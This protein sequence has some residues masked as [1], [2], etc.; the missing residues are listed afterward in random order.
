MAVDQ[1]VAVCLAIVRECLW[2]SK[3]FRSIVTDLSLPPVLQNL[4]NLEASMTERTELAHGDGWYWKP[5]AQ[6]HP[7]THNAIAT[8]MHFLVQILRP[9]WGRGS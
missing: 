6:T 9:F 7:Q 4:Q 5:L 2:T 3:A 1:T 8:P